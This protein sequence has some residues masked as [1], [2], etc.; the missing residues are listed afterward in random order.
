MLFSSVLVSLPWRLYL[1]LTAVLFSPMLYRQEQN[2]NLQ[3][4][5]QQYQPEE[6]EK[7]GTKVEGIRC[8]SRTFFSTFFRSRRCHSPKR[9]KIEF[10]RGP[11]KGKHAAHSQIKALTLT[12]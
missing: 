9:N 12:D 1:F 5:Q 6:K 8:S 10:S 2:I 4:E 11:F 7:K 3:Q